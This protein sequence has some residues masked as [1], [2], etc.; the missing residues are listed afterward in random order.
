MKTEKI[1]LKQESYSLV[2][3]SN[4]PRRFSREERFLAIQ[5]RFARLANGATGKVSLW[6]KTDAVAPFVPAMD[7]QNNPLEVVISNNKTD[8]TETLIFEN[9]GFE[10]FDIRYTR[11]PYVDPN[12]QDNSTATNFVEIFFSQS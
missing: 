1:R 12:P 3:A 9:T 2:A 7:A 10:F 8:N 5:V 6:V 11:D 4:N